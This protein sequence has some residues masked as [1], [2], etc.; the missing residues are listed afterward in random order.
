MTNTASAA[1][2]LVE[3]GTPA[4][5]VTYHGGEPIFIPCR[6]VSVETTTD[7]RAI[8]VFQTA[9]VQSSGLIGSA[10]VARKATYKPRD[11]RR[12]VVRPSVAA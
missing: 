12:V 3:R 2:H 11:G 6:V 1:S 9:I 5:W 4:Y 10:V 8:A 7:G